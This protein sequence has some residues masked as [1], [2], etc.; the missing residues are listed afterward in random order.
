MRP[1]HK[2][3]EI[4]LLPDLRNQPLF[5]SMRPRHKAAEI[6]LHSSLDPTDMHALQ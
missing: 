1:R 2:A 4:E 5:A 3:A 6:D